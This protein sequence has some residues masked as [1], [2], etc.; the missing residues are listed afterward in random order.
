MTLSMTNKFII[1]FVAVIIGVVLITPTSS[2]VLDRTSRSTATDEEVDLT[3]V[4]IE[5]TDFS[6]N[7]SGNVLVAQE[8]LITVDCI[9]GDVQMVNQTTGTSG[10][11]IL[12]ENTDYRFNTSNGQVIALNSTGMLANISTATNLTYANY[13]YCPSG[14]LNLNWGRS[15]LRLVP[16]FFGLAL[17]LVGV[18]LFF[19]IYAEFR[20]K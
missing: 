15:L 17:L 14:Y 5:D 7:E 13:T 20:N 6:F 19:Q 2:E 8:A 4:R 10:T 18:A 11:Y 9:A 1:A 12:T 3:P 16:G